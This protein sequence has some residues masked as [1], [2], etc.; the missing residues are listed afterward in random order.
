MMHEAILKQFEA[1]VGAGD[2]GSVWR[3]SGEV[4]RGEMRPRSPDNARELE[5]LIVAE[6][7]QLESTWMLGQSL[8]RQ[9]VWSLLISQGNEKFLNEALQ[10]ASEELS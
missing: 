6:N 2:V 8:E 4:F 7:E 9:L 5:T 3:W 10:C 1:K